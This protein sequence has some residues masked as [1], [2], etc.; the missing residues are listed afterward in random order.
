ML[1]KYAIC[2][3]SEFDS[4]EAQLIS[5]I[6]I[7]REILDKELVT[8]GFL[9]CKLEATVK[10]GNNTSLKMIT[11]SSYVIALMTIEDTDDVIKELIDTG[12]EDVRR[13]QRLFQ[14]L[15]KLTITPGPIYNQG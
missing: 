2:T 11:W 5:S 14:G 7:V 3:E 10:Y 6:P 12:A 9:K 8:I 15:T 4:F 13:Y 1:K